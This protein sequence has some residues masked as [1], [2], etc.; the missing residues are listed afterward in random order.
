[1]H[2]TIKLTGQKAGVFILSDAGGVFVAVHDPAGRRVA[3]HLAPHE[4]ALIGS[5][6]E[7]AAIAADKAGRAAVP[8]E[9][10]TVTP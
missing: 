9:A 7:R 3:L 2:S 4:A 5:E 8:A 1:M 6:I 10:N